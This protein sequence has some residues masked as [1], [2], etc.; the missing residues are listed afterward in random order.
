MSDVAR[1]AGPGCDRP[2]S[3]A[4]AGRR[5][6]YCGSAC[7]KAA[8]RVRDRQ[9]AAERQRAIRLA[10]ATSA[11]VR[12]WLPLQRARREIARLADAVLAYADG[13]D[14]QDLEAKLAGFR[15]ACSR[16]E[17]LAAEHFE[18]AALA[19]QLGG[20]RDF[21]EEY[22]DAAVVQADLLRARDHAGRQAR[23]V[24]RMSPGTA[25]PAVTEPPLT[26]RVERQPASGGQ[27]SQGVSP[28]GRQG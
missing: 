26:V 25:T 18:A 7:R 10:D 11:A 28:P 15:E 1:C 9:A 17:N 6:E 23:S 12:S 24:T 13:D 2:L 3:R 27:A 16:L 4:A 22:R 5:R 19:G 20:T 14:R 8:Q 21:R